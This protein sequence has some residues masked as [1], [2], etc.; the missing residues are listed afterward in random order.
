MPDT[1]IDTAVVETL[2]AAVP[3][4]TI[5]P[6]LATDMPSAYVGRE[7]LLDVCRTLR[8][9]PD[10]QFA[11]LVDVVGADYLPVEPRFEIVYHLVCIGP[12]YVTADNPAAAAPRR[13]RLKV[14]LPGA[15]ARIPTVTSIYPTANWLEREVFDLMGIAFDG[16]PDLRRILMPEDWTGY[17]LR[18]DYPVQIRKDAQSWEPLQLS[19]QEFAENVRAARA[20]ADRD[21]GKK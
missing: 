8:D 1:Q 18:K 16:H 4:A 2:R 6:G 10:L 3:A 13:F 21:A 14:R 20:K 9:H 5:E 11:L 17:P 12:A 7:H 19:P 15:D